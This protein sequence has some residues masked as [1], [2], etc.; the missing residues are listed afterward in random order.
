MDIPSFRTT[1]KGRHNKSIHTPTHGIKK[2]ENMDIPSFRTTTERR[3]QKSTTNPD[4]RDST[5][6]TANA[7]EATHAFLHQPDTG[8]VAYSHSSRSSKPTTGNDRND[9]RHRM[10]Q[11]SGAF[12]ETEQGGHAN[13][14]LPEARRGEMRDKS[15]C[16]DRLSRATSERASTKLR[17]YCSE[18]S[19]SKKFSCSGLEDSLYRPS[20]T[21][22]RE[23]LVASTGSIE[24]DNVGTG[25]LASS[26]KLMQ[27]DEPFEL[28]SFRRGFAHFIIL[29][30]THGLYFALLTLIQVQLQKKEKEETQELVFSLPMMLIPCL[31]SALSFFLSALLYGCKSSSNYKVCL[32]G[33]IWGVAVVL[34]MFLFGIVVSSV[35]KG[36]TP[37]ENAFRVLLFALSIRCLLCIGIFTDTFRNR[38]LLFVAFVLGLLLMLDRGRSMNGNRTCGPWIWLFTVLL[39]VTSLAPI[40]PSLEFQTFCQLIITIVSGVALPFFDHWYYF[41]RI[42]EPLPWILIGCAVVAFSLRQMAFSSM[43]D[44]EPRLTVRLAPHVLGPAL[45]GPIVWF[46]EP[47]DYDPTPMSKASFYIHILLLGSVVSFHALVREKKESEK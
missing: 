9:P 33:I 20:L 1:I 30:L 29:T 42:R 4:K 40:R 25:L 37:Y 26:K 13:L 38:F 8:G 43:L 14:C 31:G 34:E 28:V 35:A 46:F 32:D 12:F 45:V 15:V 11:P 39:S 17:G 2:D 41:E 36:E 44:C 27:G 16:S 3:S 6:A 5:D 21:T 23:E 10:S 7:P 47:Q 18:I 22:A 24:L 19:T